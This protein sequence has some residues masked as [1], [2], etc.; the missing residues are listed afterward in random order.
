MA[1]LSKS[2]LTFLTLAA[3]SAFST[4]CNWQGGPGASFNLS[5]N[6][7]CGAV[8]SFADTGAFTNGSSPLTITASTMVGSLQ[9]TNTSRQ[10]TVQTTMPIS[11]NTI[12]MQQSSSMQL[13]FVQ[14]SIV[15]ITSVSSADMS[16][17]T[18]TLNPSFN[19]TINFSNTASTGMSVV[20][21]FLSN[22]GTFSLLGSAFLSNLQSAASFANVS[23]GSSTL[24][25][26]GGSGSVYGG[27]IGGSGGLIVSGSGTTLTLSNTSNNFSGGVQAQ[28][29]TTLFPSGACIGS[30]TL[31]LAGGTLSPSGAFSVSNTVDV[32]ASSSIITSGSHDCTLTGTLN[33][34][35]GV[36]LNC[37]ETSGSISLNTVNIST[38]TF[39]LQG[40]LSGS[41][42][43]TKTGA[44][45]LTLA[46]TNT[47]T[48]PTVVSAGTLI[49]NGSTA[50]NVSVASGATLK[51]TGTIGGDLQMNG[52]TAIPGNSIGTIPITGNLDILDTTSIIQIEIN[53]SGQTSLLDITGSAILN[54]NGVLQ[55]NPDP[56]TYSAG[57][58][59]TFLTAAGGVQGQFQ[60]DNSSGLF[61]DLISTVVY[62]ADSIQLVLT[63]PTPPPG[64]TPNTTVSLSTRGLKGN[65]L[66]LANY[67]NSL[68]ASQLGSS[69]TALSQLDANALNHALSTI[70]PAR[71]AFA[72]Y[73][74]QITLLSCT[75]ILN[76]HALTLRRAKMTQD[77]KVAFESAAQEDSLLV[78]NTLLPSPNREKSSAFWV[79]GF[80]DWAHQSAEEENPS[81][82]AQTAGAM[83]GYDY[84]PACPWAKLDAALIGVLLAYTKTDIHQNDDFGHNEL[85]TGYLALYGNLYF[86]NTYLSFAAW[87]G[88]QF[89]D[90]ER[91]VFFS[92][93]DHTAK[94]SLK[95]YVGDLHF[96]LGY[97]FNWE[98]GNCSTLFF[99]PFAQVDWAY[100][101]SPSYHEHGAA[102][103]DM[104]IA[105]Q[106]SSML[107]SEAGVML[108]FTK[109]YEKSTWT[110]WDK[111]SY[112]NRA[113][114]GTGTMTANLVGFPGSF[115]LASLN[116]NQSLFSESI[117]LLWQSHKGAYGSLQ[118]EGEFGSGW[119]SNQII[120]TIGKQF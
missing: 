5:T 120:G 117:E 101:L 2:I 86:S 15:Q 73:M 79:N 102:P 106:F 20:V 12:G 42:T 89:I 22:Q 115:S 94:S 92:T 32:T 59:Y 84:T 4:V 43:F 49:L 72:P 65:N 26:N 114:F 37:S 76:G 31:T 67:L 82:H 83:M 75:E 119:M 78:S 77:K 40:S 103:Y 100:D 81:F 68:S 107:Q 8:P 70:Q 99:E 47:Y 9:F 71:N 105:R 21:D 90:N 1:S 35:D 36:S 41:Q 63:S 34:S 56:G 112:I 38:G 27:T 3:T 18:L 55:F 24:T 118:Y 95:A 54:G 44:G 69:F 6:W 58:T 62:N 19:S 14:Q 50:G 61:P 46:S 64:P 110:L 57:T 23:L 96:G 13:Q 98:V 53:P 66:R 108:Y 80:G 91:K 28:S 116:A 39:T 16:T 17:C 104:H 10:I 85:Q 25:L 11:I 45:T 109:T 52:G 111:V 29:G 93:F 74:A 97:D 30:G 48:Q 51:G 7:S 88:L 60:S 87:N 33:G 113:P